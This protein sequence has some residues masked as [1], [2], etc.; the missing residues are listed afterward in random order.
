M[1]GCGGA[2]LSLLASP[3]ANSAFPS[4]L[5]D[6]TMMLGNYLIPE[7]GIYNMFIAPLTNVGNYR[8]DFAT[9]A[10]RTRWKPPITETRWGSL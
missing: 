1:A 7:C 5:K 3:E 6:K 4:T 8:D 9:R 2:P 10:R